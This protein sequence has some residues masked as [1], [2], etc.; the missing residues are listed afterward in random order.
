MTST[1]IEE[2]KTK[3]PPINNTIKMV[4]SNVCPFHPCT[5]TSI[6]YKTM[7]YFIFSFLFCFCT[8]INVPPS[9]FPFPLILREHKICHLL[10]PFPLFLHEHKI[11]HLLFLFSSL[12]H[13]FGIC[14][15]TY[16]KNQIY[17]KIFHFLI[18]TIPLQH[19]SQCF[20]QRQTAFYYQIAERKD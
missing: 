7:L 20:C 5:V 6:F 14:V 8:N 4:F 11:C 1:P 19:L 16:S 3:N 10:F 12:L 2:R 17:N 13:K 18:C 15:Y 9:F